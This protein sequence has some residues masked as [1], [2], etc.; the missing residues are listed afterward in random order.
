M[1]LPTV[2]TI[3]SAI[4]DAILDGDKARR[5]DIPGNYT[6]K[7]KLIGD[8]IGVKLDLIFLLS[9]QC[10]PKSSKPKIGITLKESLIIY[11][12]YLSDSGLFA[13]FLR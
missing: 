6:T 12:S 13:F 2:R 5:S 10:K 8:Q 7:V 4:V 11:K 1:Y 3:I 9:N